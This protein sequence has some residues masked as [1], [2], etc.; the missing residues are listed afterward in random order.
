MFVMLVFFLFSVFCLEFQIR[1]VQYFSSKFPSFSRVLPA[2]RVDFGLFLFHKFSNFTPPPPSPHRTHT[3]N[4]KLTSKNIILTK[5]SISS[6]VSYIFQFYSSSSGARIYDIAH[7]ILWLFL[8]VHY[9]AYVGG[10]HP[11]ESFRAF[12]D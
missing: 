12:I 3:K 10:G 6:F 11:S 4:L 8:Y 7:P 9:A 1:L 5:S 2:N